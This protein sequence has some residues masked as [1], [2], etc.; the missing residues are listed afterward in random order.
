MTKERMVELL[1]PGS[2]QRKTNE[3][4]DFV[5]DYKQ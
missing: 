3:E 1:L 2:R 5:R 4:R